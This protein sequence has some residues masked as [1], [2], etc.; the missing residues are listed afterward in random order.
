MKISKSFF[1]LLGFTS[2]LS[3]QTLFAQASGQNPI[4]RNAALTELVEYVVE[5]RP[6][7]IQVLIDEEIGERDINAALAGWLPQIS[8]NA[9][10]SHTLKLQVSPLNMGGEISYIA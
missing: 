8:A 5:I 7:V 6:E 1:V 3:S 4:L 2:L 9:T 10:L